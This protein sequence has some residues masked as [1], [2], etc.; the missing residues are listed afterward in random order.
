MIVNSWSLIFCPK[1]NVEFDA[2]RRLRKE[3]K[4]SRVL[5]LRSHDNWVYQ[6]EARSIFSE[7][8]VSE[9]SWTNPKKQLLMH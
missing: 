9:Y 1:K 4:F 2:T 7:P 3:K 8:S 5:K 6:E